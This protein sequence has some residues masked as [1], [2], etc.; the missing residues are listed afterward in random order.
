MNT[1][2]DMIC[3]DAM[4][5][6]SGIAPKMIGSTMSRYEFQGLTRIGIMKWRLYA[7]KHY[8]V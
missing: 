4:S 2:A 8:Q 5:I 3:I 1:L 7:W 6:L